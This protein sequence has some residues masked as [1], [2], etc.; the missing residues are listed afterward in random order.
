MAAN[1]K[2]EQELHQRQP[3][4]DVDLD[5]LLQE[6]EELRQRLRD[7]EDRHLQLK[8]ALEDKNP[9]VEIKRV[10]IPGKKDEKKDLKKE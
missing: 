6:T 5:K 3:P 7:L 8:Q 10:V 4:K 1:L 2:L 9:E